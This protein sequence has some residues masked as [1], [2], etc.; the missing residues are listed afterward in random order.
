[1]Q[2]WF[3][4]PLVRY[5]HRVERTV[6]VAASK[7]PPRKEEKD[8]VTIPS[9]LEFLLYKVLTIAVLLGVANSNETLRQ[10]LRTIK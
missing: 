5:L 2:S 9:W 1:M 7:S 4:R 3:G 10:M 8:P 6:S